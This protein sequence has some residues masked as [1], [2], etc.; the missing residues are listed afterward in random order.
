M[1]ITTVK[2]AIIARIDELT[3]I[4]SIKGLRYHEKTAHDF[5]L[6]G[7]CAGQYVAT[8]RGVTTSFPKS[9][10]RWNL[11]I[12]KNNLQDYLNT[13]VP[14]ELAHAIQRYHYPHSTPHGKEW[15][16]CCVALIGHELSRC[17]TFAFTPARKTKK[18][19]YTCN[20]TTHSVSSVIHNRII[21]G[22]H[23]TCNDCHSR[24]VLQ[25]NFANTH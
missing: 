17:H 6:R 23:Y 24:I 20:C 25:S 19:T 12:A 4:A 21:K 1:D 10:L 2:Q 11:D 9:T 5:T 3:R 18:Y 13:T 22:R 15:K 16:R 14:H 8:Y 7:R